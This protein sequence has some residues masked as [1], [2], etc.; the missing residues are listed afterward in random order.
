MTVTSKN[1]D[2]VLKQFDFLKSTSEQ[3]VSDIIHTAIINNNFEKANEILKY[4]WEVRQSI[5]NLKHI[6]ACKQFGFIELT[7]DEFG[8]IERPKWHNIEKIEFL[9]WNNSFEIGQGLN[10]TWTYG[11]SASH[12]IGGEYCGLN[13]FNTPLSKADALKAA[14]SEIEKFHHSAIDDTHLEE[15]SKNVSRKVLRIIK[16]YQQPKQLQLF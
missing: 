7:N 2:R 13:E 8:W 15:A 4:G 16:E 10:G 6:E 5:M 9:G 12:K 11:Y 3:V 14:I 1:K